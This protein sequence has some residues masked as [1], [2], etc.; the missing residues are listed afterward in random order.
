[1][2]EQIS[3]QKTDATGRLAIVG[4]RELV[5]GYRLIGIDDT[6]IVDDE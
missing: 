6:F 4:D 1:M 2:S 5:I 3:K